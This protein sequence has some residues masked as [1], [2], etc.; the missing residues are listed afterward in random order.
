M[1]MGVILSIKQKDTPKI[2]A[3]KNKAFQKTQ[4]GFPAHKFT[5]KIKFGDDP[6][7]E[8]RKLRDEWQ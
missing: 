6:V 4:S 8:Q 1:V 3:K 5:G 7:L 2:L